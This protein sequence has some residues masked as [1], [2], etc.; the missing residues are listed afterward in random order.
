MIAGFDTFGHEG[1]KMSHIPAP[2]QRPPTLS[3]TPDNATLQRIAARA[4]RQIELLERINARL[5]FIVWAIIL[6]IVLSFLGSLDS[7]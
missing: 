3:P 7:F 6:S 1:E 2:Q 5:T 4:N